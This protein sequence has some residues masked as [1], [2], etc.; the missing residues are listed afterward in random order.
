MAMNV[1]TILG[2][3]FFK[4]SVVVNQDHHLKCNSGL[5]PGKEKSHKKCANKVMKYDSIN[6]FVVEIVKN[7]TFSAR[8]LCFLA[9]FRSTA[10]IQYVKMKTQL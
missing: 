3:F 7:I 8:I 1:M 6:K 2:F 9:D 4:L 10:L 5:S